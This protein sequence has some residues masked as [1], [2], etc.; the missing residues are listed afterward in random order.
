MNCAKWNWFLVYL[1]EIFMYLGYVTLRLIVL[2]WDSLW[3]VSVRENT[4]MMYWN[5]PQLNSSTSFS[6]PAFTDPNTNRQYTSSSRC[7]NN[8]GCAFLRR[9]RNSLLACMSLMNMHTCSAVACF[10]G[11]R[12]NGQLLLRSLV[13]NVLCKVPLA[14]EILPSRV[15]VFYMQF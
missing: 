11:W 10:Q 4:Q 1:N 5:H 14:S 13:Y 8:W 6:W 9:E 15:V 7:S 3:L 12:Q 2:T